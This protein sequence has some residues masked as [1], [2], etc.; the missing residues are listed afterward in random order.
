[1]LQG[2]FVKKIRWKRGFLPYIFH[3]QNH[4]GHGIRNK[5]E[6]LRIKN[7]KSKIKNQES[8]MKNEE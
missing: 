8:R 7:E 1:L 6:E 4:A 2:C 5:N 3:A